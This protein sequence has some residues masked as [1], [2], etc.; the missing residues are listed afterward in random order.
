MKLTEWIHQ[1]GIE[2]TAT[3]L[4][5]WIGVLCGVIQVLLAKANN[6]LLYP[7][8]IASILITIYVLYDAGLYAEL[9]LNG[10][11]LVMSIYG[12]IY[13]MKRPNA[14]PV[15]ATYSGKR[16]WFITS[17][18]VGVGFP[19][20]YYTLMHFTDSTV[21]A[22]DAWVSATAWAGMWLLAKRKIENWVLLN[23][24]NAFAIP[25]LIHKDL[26]LFAL[27]TLF[28]FVV[29]IFGYFQWRRI[30]YTQIELTNHR[31]EEF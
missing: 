4:L 7:F 20:L 5:H 21:P 8:G 14:E 22:W 9:L 24:S 3:P 12:W 6:V 18:I 15:P 31:N 23:V 19:M 13:W 10:Y 1:L 2:L 26:H 30:I 28:L 17:L 16:D 27:L 29:A 11:Y 25:L